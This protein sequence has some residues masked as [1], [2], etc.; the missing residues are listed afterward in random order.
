MSFEPAG[1]SD[2]T[3]TQAISRDRDD[4]RPRL[5]CGVFGIHGMAD[6]GAL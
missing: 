3:D 5:E 1:L 2:L 6:A 4:D